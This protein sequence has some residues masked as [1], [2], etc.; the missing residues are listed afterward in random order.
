MLGVPAS[1]NTSVEY[2]PHVSKH[3]EDNLIHVKYDLKTSELIVYLNGNIFDKIPFKELE[4]I[5]NSTDNQQPSYLTVEKLEAKV[6]DEEDEEAK[7]EDS[8]ESL[9]EEIKLNSTYRQRM[10]NKI[11]ETQCQIM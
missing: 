4:V 2:I 1:S 8:F 3:K 6:V 10:V 7:E 9:K 5:N 11:W